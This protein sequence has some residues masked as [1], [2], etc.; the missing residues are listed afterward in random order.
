IL[1]GFWCDG[2][3]TGVVPWFNLVLLFGA[4][5][6]NH[7]KVNAARQK[8]SKAA[9]TVNNARLVNTAHPKRTMNAA[10]P[11]PKV[12]TARPKAVLN[13]VQG[14]HI[15]AVKAS[16]LTVLTLV[17]KKHNFKLTDESHV[18]IK[19]P[20]KD[21]MY[22]VDLKNVVPQR[23]I[24]NIIDLRM[25]MIRCDNRTEFKNRVMNQLCEMKGIKKKFSVARTPQQNG[26]AKKKNRTLIEA[27]RTML[28]DSNLPTTFWA[29]AVDTAC[30]KHALSFM[31]PFGCPV[32]ILNTID[33]LGKFDGKADEG[34]F[35]GYST[36][37]KAFRIF[38]NRTSIVEENL[39]VKFNENTPNIAGSGPNWLFDIDALT[40]SM[41]YKLIV[42]G[43]QSNGSA[44]TKACDNVGKSRVET[45]EKKDAEDPENEDS[46]VPS[47]EEPRVNQEKDANVNITNN[48][49]TV[50]PTDNA[51]GIE[52]NAVDENIVYGCADDPNMPDLE[53]ISRFSDAENDD[54]GADMNNLDT[55]FQVSHV[56][57]TRIHKDHPFG[58]VIGD[59]HLAS[60]KKR[61]SKNMEGHGLVST[62]NQRTNLK[63]LQNCLFA[64]FLSQIEPKKV[65]RNKLD[66]RRIMIRKKARL[67]AQGHT[68]GEGIDYDEVF[69]PVARIEAI[70]LFL[71]YALFKDFVVYQMDVKSAFLY[72]K[73]EEEVYVCQP[74]S[75]KDPEFPDKVYKVE[76]ALYGLHQAP[77]A[78]KE[79]CTELEKMIHTKFQMSS[80]GELT[81]FLGLQVKQKEDG[82]VTMVANSTTQA[83]YVAALSC[84]GQVLWIQNQLLDYGYNLM[85]TK[86]HIDNKSTICIVKN[87]VFHSKTKHIKIRHHFIRDSNEKKLIQMIKIHNDKNIADLLTKAFDATAKVKNMNREAQLH[88]K[89]DGKKVVPSEA[90]IRRDLRFGDEGGIDC[91]SNEVIYEQLTLVGTIASAVIFL[92]TYQKFNFSKYIFDIMVKNLDNAT[93]F[94][95]FPRNMKRVGKGF[96]RKDTPLFPTMMK[97]VGK[98]FSRKDTPL[99]PTMMVQAQ[100]ELDE[101][102]NEEIY[103]SLERAN[104]TATGLDAEQDRGNI[105]K[106]QS[107]ATLNEPSFIGTSSGSGPW[108]QD[109]M[110]TRSERVSNF[111]N[112]PPLLRVNILRSGEDILK[113]KELMELCTKLSDRVLNLETTKTS[114]AQEITSLKKR[115][116]RLEK[117]TR[118]RTHG[119]KRLY[120]VG[121]STRVESSA[122]EESLSEEDA[123]KQ[124]RISDIDANQD[125]YLVNVHREKDIFGVNDLDDTSMFDADKDLQGKEVVV[126]EVNVASI[127]TSVTATTAVSFD[128]LTLAQ[129][130]VE[131]KTSKPKAKGIIMQEPSEATT[132]TIIIPLIKSQDK[133]K[134]IMIEPEMPLNN[135]AQISLAKIEAD[136]E[137]AQRLQEEKEEQE[138]LTDAEKA[139]LFMEF[140]EKRRKFFAAKRAEEKRNKPPTKAQ[141]R[142]IISTYLKNMDGWKPRALKNKS[143]A[144]IKEL[145]NKTMTRINNF[146]DFRTELV[147]MST[148]K[149]KAE[150]AQESSSTRAGNELDQERSKK[151]KIEYENEFAEL[152]RYLEIVSNDG[153]DVTIDATPLSF[154]KMLKNFDKEDLE[155]LWRLVKDRFVKTKPIDNMDSFLMHSLKTMFEHHVEDTTKQHRKP[156]RKVT[157]VSLPNDPT[158]VPDEAVN[159]ERDNSLKRATTT[160]T[161]LDAERHRGNII[162]TNPRQHLTSLVPKELVQVVVLGVNTPR[163][164]KDS[165]KLHELTELCTKL[166]QRVLDLETTKTTQALEIHNLNKRVKK[167]E[168][169]KSSRTHGLKRLYKVGLS[170]R[171][172]SSKYEGLGEE[173]ASK[174]GRI[175]DID[176]NEDITLVITTA[177][178]TPTISIDEVTLAQALAELKHT[179]PKAKAKGTV[180]HE[181]EEST[182]TTTA[183][184][185]KSKSQ[186]K[187]KAKMIEEPVKLKKIKSSLMKE[188]ALKLQAE[189]QAKFEKEQ[190]LAGERAQQKVEVNIALIESE[191]E[192]VLCCKESRRKE[193]QTINTSSTKKNNIDFKMV[194]TFVDFRTEL[195]E[196]SSMKNK[197]KVI[198]GSSKRAGTELEQESAKKQKIDDDKDT[199]ELQYPL[200]DEFFTAENSSVSKSSI[201]SDNTQHQDTQPTM[202]VQPTTEL[203]TPT[204]TVHAEENNDNQAA[205][206]RFKPYEFINPLYSAK[207]KV[208][209]ENKKE[210]D[211]TIIHNK[212]RLM[213]VKTEFLN[214]PLKKVVYVAQPNGFVDPDHPEKVYH[215]RKALYGLKQASR[216]WY[217]ELSTFLTSKGFTKGTIDPTLFTI[218]YEDDILRVQIYDFGFELTVFLDV[219]H[220][221]CLDTRKI[222]FGG[223]QFLGEKLVS[224]IS[225]KQDCT[226]MST[227]EAEYVACGLCSNNVDEDTA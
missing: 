207:T 157:E 160:A 108:R 105:A 27:A 189:S 198:E 183:A 175:A 200:Y 162:K 190:R 94:L 107:K 89:V 50:S 166:Q 221:R 68:Q 191:K 170:T 164:G 16:A 30:R 60:Q 226:E 224:W 208:V 135:E 205:N 91:F 206:A 136:Y 114:Q 85:Q 187:G 122:D 73:I 158:S 173:D 195:I 142:S 199:T 168:R 182:T 102:I 75:F 127:A 155:V 134:G 69:A 84:C 46:E 176:A 139:K 117:K 61:M 67:V 174:Q 150:I 172:E 40:K 47:I 12:N 156:K 17:L 185:P 41:N 109:T 146:V 72:G 153:D 90:S 77:R 209:V 78:W 99:F 161:S 62:V 214:Y 64:C 65:F 20:R 179:K 49:N 116:K 215:L 177:A 9:V 11:R 83:E 26:V 130:L 169:R 13:D 111:S 35:V 103:D 123:S 218:R 80:I 10:K 144:E 163:S 227:T 101:A 92:A 15:N 24:K 1:V 152:K 59:L 25:K 147:E 112:D 212:A 44:G 159:E 48:V 38:N 132:T 210:E 96:S 63:D 120:K 93:K 126:K 36:N 43:N 58:Q 192:E 71:A 148:K 86:I 219:D 57:T 56:P 76:K 140:L 180:F 222:T 131:I 143:F 7:K 21:N 33:H 3:V 55:Y 39:H 118:S 22:S 95:M 54:L 104:T 100:E 186:D 145:F 51:A 28:A 115:V 6:F 167:L 223:I 23:G 53:E 188:V 87:L 141:Q 66:K 4:I 2:V 124:G 193:E 88:V 97:R 29:E 225:K 128:E 125:I 52:D 171:V 154:N 98:G 165:L 211:N 202:N 110:G 213:D 137:M 201:L 113:L 5:F 181:P 149:D 31:R 203:I 129:A 151:Q 138:Q 81:F 82:I 70:R 121:L 197:A 133:D 194:N 34:L 32:T 106:I 14:N 178:T 217:D 37:S 204:T 19:V 18:L 8:F 79:M 184:I 119:L 42:T 220:A 196:E 74:P 45:E 216:A